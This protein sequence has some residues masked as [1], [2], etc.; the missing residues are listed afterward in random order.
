ML[1]ISGHSPRIRHQCKYII[2]TFCIYYAT[3]R[4]VVYL[5][6]VKSQKT[7]NR[8]KNK[9]TRTQKQKKETLFYNL[10]LILI[11]YRP[12][13]RHFSVSRKRVPD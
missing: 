3:K 2:L 12:P 7:C 9:Q 6:C 5:L 11:V 13:I 1:H 4:S 8:N 10:L